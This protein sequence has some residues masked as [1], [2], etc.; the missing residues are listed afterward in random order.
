[1]LL[2]NDGFNFFR[3]HK[4]TVPR[5]DMPEEDYLV[6]LELAFGK[7]GIKLPFSQSLQ[8]NPKMENMLFYIPWVHQDIFDEDDYK[9]II[10]SKRKFIQLA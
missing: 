2:V 7:L 9:L 8:Y 1:M 5:N 6:K 3:I 4:N 10:I